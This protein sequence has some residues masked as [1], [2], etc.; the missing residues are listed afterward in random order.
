MI[1]RQFYIYKFESKFLDQNKYNINLSFKQAK[2]GDQIIAV[3]DSQMLRSIRDIQQRYIDRYKLELLFK[4]RDDIKKLPSSKTNASL[5]REI[6]KQINMMMFVPE[7]VSVIITR[8]SHYKKLFYNGL[9]INGKK[10]IRFSCSASQARVNTIIMVQQDISDE[11]Y[12]RLNNG[13]H[14]KKLNP[15]KFN[16]YFGLSSS[17]TISVSTPRVCVVSDCLMKRNTLVNYVTEIDEP[18][19]DDIIERKEVE[20]EYNYFDGMGLIS[21]EQSERWAHELELDW[22]PSEW[23]IRNAWIKGMV[24]TF[25]IQEFCEKVNGGNYLIETIYKNEDGTPKMADLRNIDVIISESQFKMAG[26]YDSYEEYERNCINNKLSWGISRYTPKYDSNCLY[27]NYQSLQTLKLDDED[28]SQLCAPTVDWIKG[29]AR[30]NIMYTSLFLMGKSVG[31]KGVVNFINSSDNYWLKSL[32][33]NHNVINDKYVSDKIYDNIVNKIKSACMGK[34]VVN[35]NYQVLVSD[36]YAM[37][38]HVCGLEPNGLL[39]EREYY[40]KY[41]NDRNIDLVD[42]MRSPLT[43]RSEHNILNLK[44][45]DELNHW[46]RYLGTGIIVN[47]HS[48]DVLRWADS[49]FDMDIVATTSNPT[50]IKGVYKDD[51]AVTYQKK[52]SQ[53]IEFTQEDLYKADLLAFGSEIGSIT[54]K[55]TSM[56]AMLPMYD[57]QSPQYAELE[58]RL[59]MTRV[60]QGNAIDKAKGVQTKQF[61]QHWANY[62]RIEDSDSDEVKRK[63]EFFNSILVEKKPYFFK[64]LYKDSRSAYNKFLR[65][66]ES[67]RQIYGIDL[68]EIKGKNE[69][70]LTEKEKYYLASMNYRNPLI[71]SDCEMNRICRYIESVDFDIKRFNSDKPYDYK[72]YMNDSIEKNMA[73]YNS[74]KKAVKDFF[75]FLKED[76]SMSDYSSS[77]KYLPEEERK[78]MNKYD[79]F[80][81]TMTGIC[82]N[83]SELVNYLVEIFYVDLKSSN[84]DI[85]WRTFGKVMFYNVYNKSS[86]KVLIPQIED[87]GEYEYLFDSYNILEVD[88]IGQ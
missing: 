4:K 22:I 46:Y 5:I 1:N 45:N 32:L 17:A 70:E 41:W 76:I 60:A 80:K 3:S 25:P 68:D 12:R 34:L 29:V 13:R 2:D 87:D 27:L 75:R 31:K 72:I 8:P 56:Y 49:D 66:E 59:I 67:Y 77:L 47:V 69:S 51:L 19:C 9:T 42:S 26:C 36:P 24:C 65:E 53:K 40:S 55:S 16:A 54:N 73:L 79:L 64:Y 20:I 18:L 81:D 38:E 39:G 21:P 84:K 23:C 88:L 85:L 58:R 44:N 83:S 52:L 33:V 35:G 78:L 62:Q 15:S 37:M 82:S 61:P 7:Y 74:V 50:I 48:D 10:Y 30:D 28:V 6:N 14:D 71:E 63:K 57:P 43:Y 86:K 11:L